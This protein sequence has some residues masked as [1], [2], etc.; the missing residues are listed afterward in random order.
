MKFILNTPQ[1][2]DLR[3]IH[4]HFHVFHDHT[5]NLNWHI[6]LSI[7]LKCQ[8]II[9]IKVNFFLE[10]LFIFYSFCDKSCEFFDVLLFIGNCCNTNLLLIK[11][12]INF[13][14]HLI[15]IIKSTFTF[16]LFP[17]IKFIKLFRIC[18]QLLINF[19]IFI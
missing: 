10:L 4:Y 3:L 9:S 17:D 11:L 7:I 2:I 15:I 14:Q 19:I 5:L 13:I 12:P 16:S 18:C 1:L 6:P 8:T